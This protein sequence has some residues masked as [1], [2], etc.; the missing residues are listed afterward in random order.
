MPKIRTR[1]STAK[2]FKILGSGRIRRWRAYTG[3]LLSHKTRKQKRNLRQPDLV[4][5][6]DEKKILRQLG[7][8]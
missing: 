2:R 4:D 8:R 7:L 1:K 6:S 5:A 3:H